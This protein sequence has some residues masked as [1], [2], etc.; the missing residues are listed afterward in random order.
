MN[1]YGL[2]NYGVLEEGN[3]FGDISIFLNQSNYFSYFFNPNSLEPVY[4]LT[5]E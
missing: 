4:L 2:L 1:K 5:I 3:Y